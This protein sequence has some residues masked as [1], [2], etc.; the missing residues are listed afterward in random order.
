MKLIVAILMACILMMLACF[1]KP[2]RRLRYRYQRW[3]AG[4]GC[5]ALGNELAGELATGIDSRQVDSGQSVPIS[6]S[7]IGAGK[8]LLW[9]VGANSTAAVRTA[10]LCAGGVA[11]TKA[12]RPIGLSTDN[13]YQAGD[14]INLKLL[15]AV[16]GT[17]V[18]ISAG[19]ITD[20][21][22]L[23]AGPNGT[24]QTAAAPTATASYWYIG[25]ATKTVTGA[26]QEISF[27][28]EAPSVLAVTNGAPN[29]Y[30]FGTPL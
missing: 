4:P 1:R 22:L 14:I 26:G 20:G 10:Q 15:G 8:Y 30:A 19:A 18:G 29:T 21:D 5:F 23:I 12:N 13:P 16:P 2:L 11:A 7:Y 27:I 25:I 17:L 6:N 3:L 28:P 9:Q 24:V